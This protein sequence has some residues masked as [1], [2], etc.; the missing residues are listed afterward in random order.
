MGEQ[1][2]CKNFDYFI[3]SKCTLNCKLCSNYIP[4]I[5][6]PFHTPKETSFQEMR[7][8]F[9]IWDY[10][11]RIEFIGGEPLLH[12]D[13]KE[14]LKESLR[15]AD[16]FGKI[17]ITT[18]ATILPS[19]ELF[20]IIRGSDK[21]IEFLLDNYGPLSK[22]LDRIIEKCTQYGIPYRV[23]TYCGDTQYANGWIWFGDCKTERGYTE[24]EWRDVFDRCVVP[25]EHF[26]MVNNGKAFFC[27]YA[28]AMHQVTGALPEDGGYIDLFDKGIPLSEKREQ[29]KKIWQ[30]PFSSCKYCTGFDVEKAKRY[31]AAEQLPK[32]EPYVGT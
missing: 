30:G 9:R 26:V 10:A 17:R 24:E 22:N 23:D 16:Q 29:A 18:N 3:T 25:T 21:R 31:P 7:E 12:P 1:I 6:K 19:E 8:F 4:Y 15:Y 28:M 32:R 27:D 2:T 14:I 20:S 13:F 5:P 11:D